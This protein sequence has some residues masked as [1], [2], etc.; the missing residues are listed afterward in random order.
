M[1]KKTFNRLI[2]AARRISLSWGPRK[3]VKERCK[4]D[5]AV[6]ECSKCGLYCYEGKSEKNFTAMK[7]KYPKKKFSME[8]L[9]MD[10]I[11]PVIATDSKAHDWNVYFE[12]LF[13][14]EDNYR[15]L[16]KDCHGKKT[17]QENKIR[18]AVKYGK[19]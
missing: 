8:Y 12:R 9:Q 16:C 7:A 11:I 1:D 4:V 14:G 6:Y 18:Y 13:C 10:H 17:K 19:K 5:K 2:Q 3:L 15:G